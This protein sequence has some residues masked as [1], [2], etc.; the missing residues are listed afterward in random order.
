LHCWRGI[1]PSGFARVFGRICCVRRSRAS[2]SQDHAA[3][4]F[5]V[6]TPAEIGLWLVD[7]SGLHAAF[8]S[9]SARAQTS[10]TFG[11]CAIRRRYRAIFGPIWCGISRCA[12]VLMWGVPIR[13]VVR[14]LTMDDMWNVFRF[15]YSVDSIM[16]LADG[17]FITITGK[18]I[19]H[20]DSLTGSTKDEN[21]YATVIATV[22][23]LRNLSRRPDG[24]FDSR[25]TRCTR[26]SYFACFTRS[27][28]ELM[29]ITVFRR[30]ER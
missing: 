25:P 10:Q 9:C 8:A 16:I 26:G 13:R 28:C 6:F 30:E 7:C 20:V 3:Q 21:R 18:P 19:C 29:D 23:S 17:K 24:S 14:S 5:D 27:G 4:R 2:S 12:D 22:I 1:K 15:P 11:S